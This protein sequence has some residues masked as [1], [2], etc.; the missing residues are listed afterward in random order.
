MLK[1]K[2]LL[3]IIFNKLEGLKK[4]KLVNFWF[5]ILICQNLIITIINTKK[6]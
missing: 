4:F 1:K 6:Q 2:Y 3:L 5:N